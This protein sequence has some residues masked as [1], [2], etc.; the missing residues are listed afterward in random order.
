MKKILLSLVFIAFI[1]FKANA[2][3]EIPCGIYDDKTRVKLIEEHMTTIEKSINQII[4]N[5]KASPI[6]YNQLVRWVNNKEEHANKIMHIVFQYFMVQRIK[7]TDDKDLDK[8]NKKML[9][10]LHSISVYA[11]KLK[12]TTDISYIKKMKDALHEFTHLYFGDHAH[13]H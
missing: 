13:K 5:Q 10:E 3:C 4:A 7:V 12:Q 11:M 6:N 2:H 8:K 9:K 1:A